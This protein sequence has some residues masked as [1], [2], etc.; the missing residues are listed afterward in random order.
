MYGGFLKLHLHARQF[1]REGEGMI[2][3]SFALMLCLLAPSTVAAQDVCKVTELITQMS[4]KDGPLDHCL[5]GDVAHFQI[6]PEWVPYSSVA[7]RY[8]DF[9]RE[10]LVE[11]NPS[12]S[13]VHLVCVYHWKWAKQVKR[14][15][16][17][18][19]N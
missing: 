18:D 1:A 10:I 8:C 9:S 5:E 16:H 13:P 7:A 6:D 12:G 15:P 17:P 11:V 19:A 14:K 3:I 2:R 4:T